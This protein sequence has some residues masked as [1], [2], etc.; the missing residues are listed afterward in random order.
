M[1]NP[2]NETPLE[3][4]KTGF[5]TSKKVTGLLIIIFLLLGLVIALVLV[6]QRQIIQKRAAVGDV[7][8]Q[9]DPKDKSASINEEFDVNVNLITGNNKISGVDL[10]LFYDKTKLAVISITRDSVIFPHPVT[11]FDPDP[12]ENTEIIKTFDN[13]QGTGR[14]VFINRT[15]TLPSGTFRIATIR[16]KAL[17]ETAAGTPAKLTFV[18]NP[19]DPASQYEV[20]GETSSALDKDFNIT[21]MVSGT[22]IYSGDYVITGGGGTPTPTPTGGVQNRRD[23]T[24]PGG[25]PDGNV[26][27]MDTIYLWRQPFPCGPDYGNLDQC[28]SL[29][30][31]DISSITSGISDGNVN[32]MDTTCLVRQPFPCGPDYGNVCLVCG[33]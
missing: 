22:T 11:G 23:M 8:I 24:G 2:T 20:A 7:Q 26:N 15:A 29:T 25:S 18:N 14:F 19:T 16:L 6:R 4:E 27:N 5:W 32:N 1:T 17:T 10:R 13:N 33:Q 31:R 12:I 28:V 21:N 3:T 30:S 9:L